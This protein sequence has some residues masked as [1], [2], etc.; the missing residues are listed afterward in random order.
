[1]RRGALAALVASAPVVSGHA[2]DD[3]P[4]PDAV[5]Y[6]PSVST[7]AALTAPGWLEGEIGGLNVYDRHADDAAS[8]RR[9]SVPY[10]LKYAFTD[11][12]G[13]R[14]GGEALV[15]ARADDGSREMGVGDTAVIGKRRFPVSASSAFGLEVGVLFPTARRALASGSGE[16]DWSINGI[17]STDVGAW[18]ADANL[19]GTRFGARSQGQA[20]GQALGAFSVSHPLF[21]RWTLDGEL[22]GTRQ[23][24]AS[25]T[26]QFL[27]ALSY[28]VRR[29]LIVD[30]GAAHGLNRATPTWAAFTGVTVVMGRVD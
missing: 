20:R 29:D 24:G 18:H 27:A 15:H 25:S 17:Y 26:S 2:A 14:I 8:G 30:V 13:V 6:R 19:I 11:D 22:S 7:P 12:W 23:H 28:A 21:G 16:P 9:A 4:R 10:S 5:P 3:E 1:M